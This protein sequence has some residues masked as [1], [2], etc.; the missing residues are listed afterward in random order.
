MEMN[1]QAVKFL[2]SCRREQ[3]IKNQKYNLKLS[4][5]RR[6]NVPCVASLWGV[7]CIPEKFTF[8]QVNPVQ[9]SSQN[10]WNDPIANLDF[11]LMACKVS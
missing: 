9:L 11:E 1:C 3:L 8:G 4:A 6:C 2:K 7:W 10:L 5:Q